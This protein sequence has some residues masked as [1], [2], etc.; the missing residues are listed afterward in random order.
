MKLYYKPG[1]CS[2]AA[3]IALI[4]AKAPY[5]LE[6][7]DTAAGLTA[8]GGD[9]RKV[10]SRGYVPALTLDDGAVI[11]ESAAVLQAIAERFPAASLAPAIGGLARARLQELLSFLSSELHKAFGPFFAGAPLS[12]E[13]RANA[14]QRLARQIDHVEA[15]L[16]DGRSFLLGANV[17]VADF[18]AFVILNWTNFIGVSL[19][20]WPRTAAFMAQMAQRPSVRRAMAEEGLA[21]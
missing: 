15:M 8:T 4:E 10:N 13:G 17:T 9:Y 14:E 19:E 20:P 2:M 18:Y 21:A 12:P 5:D 16:A 11:T 1:A 7:V 3:H 6:K